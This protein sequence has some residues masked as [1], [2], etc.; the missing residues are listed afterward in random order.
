MELIH[1]LQ[2]VDLPFIVHAM[3]AITRLGGEIF[4]ILILPVVYWCWRKDIALPLASLLLITLFLNVL[5]K[6]TLQLPRPDETVRLISVSGYGF[7]SGHSQAPMVLWGFLAWNTR[8]YWWPGLIIFLVGFSRVYLG[9]H[10]FQDVIAGWLIGFATLVCGIA[11]IKNLDRKSL[12]FPPIPMAFLFVFLGI[13]LPITV[14]HDMTVR[15]GGLMAGTMSGIMLER[16][17][18]GFQPKTGRWRQLMKIIVGV[19]VAA[20]LWWALKIALPVVT[21]TVWIRYLLVG[22]WI[23]LGAPWVFGKLWNQDPS[24]SA[25]LFT[26]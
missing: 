25:R 10:F 13:L 2:Q 19:G 22:L 3:I 11:V 8:S 17:W 4:Y 26:S 15:A 7:P 12:E 20:G 18:V 5:L 23:G 24:K 9:V 14:S 16:I 1:L 6:E 21:I